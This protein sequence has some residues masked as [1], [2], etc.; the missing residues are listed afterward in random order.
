MDALELPENDYLYIQISQIE[1]AGFGLFTAINI[2]KNEIIAIFKGEILSNKEAKIR[3]LNNQDAYFINLLSGK[4]MDSM[5]VNCFAKY[6]NDANGSINNFKN[7]AQIQ[8][9]DNNKIAIVATK[10]IK[11]S[12]EIFCSYGKK[13]WLKKQNDY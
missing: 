5:L 3:A 2:Y 7:N 6:A 8:M 1:N 11:A 10:N 9:T 12:S 13:Y 4:I